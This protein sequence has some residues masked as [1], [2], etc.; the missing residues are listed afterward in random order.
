MTRD[1]VDYSDLP[2]EHT[3]VGYLRTRLPYS[4][5]E[6]HEQKPQYILSGPLLS[7]HWAEHHNFWKRGYIYYAVGKLIDFHG[8]SVYWREYRILHT[9]KLRNEHSGRVDHLSK[10]PC[11]VF[12]ALQLE[13]LWAVVTDDH[14]DRERAVMTNVTQAIEYC[15]KAIQTHAAYRAT[16]EFA[17]TE[18]HDLG[19]IYK[20]LPEELQLEMRTES[21][22]FA[23]KYAAFRQTIEDKILQ[24]KERRFAPPDFGA[25]PDVVAWKNIADEVD[26]TTYTAFVGKNDPAS[27]GTVG[28]KPE[29]WFDRAIKDIGKITYHRYSPFQGRDEYPVEPIHLGLMLGR[30]MYEHLFPVTAVARKES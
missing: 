6:I 19:K 12:N 15:L 14:L 8:L 24:L 23:E 13:K 18:G 29:E 25:R 22:A 30:F 7:T 2:S 4:F 16:G 3:W 28:C 11:D 20:S 26:R 27:A 17:F 1:V 9:D 5:S 21:V 10:Q